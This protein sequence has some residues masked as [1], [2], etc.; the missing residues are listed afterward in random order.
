MVDRLRLPRLLFKVTRA[1]HGCVARLGNTRVVHLAL[2]PLVECALHA[3]TLVDGLV[4]IHLALL[5][6]FLV[7]RCGFGMITNWVAS[8]ELAELIIRI[9]LFAEVTEQLTLILNRPGFN[10]AG[11]GARSQSTFEQRIG[12]SCGAS[13]TGTIGR[14]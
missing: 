12:F 9:F 5:R 14:T 6:V 7:C 13:R 10:G 8:D 4:R 1:E 2:V 11:S 3:A